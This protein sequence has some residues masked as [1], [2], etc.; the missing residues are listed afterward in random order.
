MHTIQYAS[1]GEFEVWKACFY[2]S[3]T[4]FSVFMSIIASKIF[5][6]MIFLGV[7][8]FSSYFALFPSKWFRRSQISVLQ[9]SCHNSTNISIDVWYNPCLYNFVKHPS[10]NYSFIEY[11]YCEPLWIGAGLPSHAR[12]FLF[13]LFLFFYLTCKKVLPNF[14]LS[15]QPLKQLLNRVNNNSSGPSGN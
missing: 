7:S 14:F 1:D 11:W 12:Y 10:K 9:I 2:F 15:L 3:S 13:R 6:A 4:I 8:K 5:Q